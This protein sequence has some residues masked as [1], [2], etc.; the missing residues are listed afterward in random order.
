MNAGSS[1]LMPRSFRDQDL[2][3]AVLT[4]AIGGHSGGDCPAP[5]ADTGAAMAVLTAARMDLDRLEARLLETTQESAVW[6]AIARVLGL[7]RAALDEY[8][9]R[10][11]SHD[12]GPETAASS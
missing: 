2:L 5:A 8:V 10:L 9:R 6:T 4:A 1:P 11:R 12:N 3:T 7:T